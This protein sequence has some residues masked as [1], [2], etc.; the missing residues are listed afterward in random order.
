[1]S[2][3]RRRGRDEINIFDRSDQPTPQNAADAIYGFDSLADV[4]SGQQIARPVSIFDIQPDFTQPRRA[5]PSVVRQHWSGEPEELPR[6]FD[7]WLRLVNDERKAREDHQPFDL[8]AYLSQDFLPPGVEGNDDEQADVPA[9]EHLGPVEK[10]L[11]EVVALAS[12]IR[13]VGLTNP[14]TIAR[15]G[16]GFRLETGERR[17]LAFHL[18]NAHFRH[19]NWTKIPAHM[20][21]RVSVWR[22]ASENNA[23]QDLNAVGRARQFAILLMD[24]RQEHNGDTFYSHQEILESGYTEREYYAQ[25]ADGDRYR[26]PYG[27]GERLLNAMG[28]KNAVQLR[29]YRALLRLPDDLWQ[30]ADDHNLTEGEIRKLT[31]ETVT[32]VTVVDAEHDIEAPPEH[33]LIEPTNRQRRNR[34]WT[35]AT[36]LQ[37]LSEQDRQ[38]ALKEIEADER[39]LAELKRAIAQTKP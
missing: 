30:Y 7:A 25:V 16:R 22:Q 13:R 27:Q 24:L 11:L 35:Y 8:A 9:Q 34:V 2:K 15:E 17:W 12:S 38:E 5:I 21:D 37:S 19:E 39:W 4:D 20:V 3:N 10:A 31:P 6:L 28:L 29:Q 26:I 36:R 18:L 33:P 32:R 14:I 1:M 23:R